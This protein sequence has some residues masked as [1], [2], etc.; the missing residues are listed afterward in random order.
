MMSLS[1]TAHPLD[2]SL[3]LRLKETPAAGGGAI[4]EC[5]TSE[6]Y[7]NAIGPFGGWIAA[8]LLKGV[9]SA[10]NL[11]GVPL[12]LDAQFMGAM[13]AS[14]LE[15]HV[16]PLRQNRT[17]GFW[18]SEVWQRGRMT[19]HAQVTMTARRQSVVLQDARFPRVPRPRRSRP[20]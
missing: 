1:N 10:P 13:D 20:L 19:A 17:V 11:R 15:V 6:R 12:A 14:D 8:L 18:R 4:L 9:L 3:D 5:G 2:Q 7:R 16:Y